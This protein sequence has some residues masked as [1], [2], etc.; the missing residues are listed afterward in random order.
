M[1]DVLKNCGGENIL[2]S[3]LNTRD[4]LEITKVLNAFFREI[5]E[6]W[7]EINFENQ[8]MSKEHFLDQ[9]LW[10]NSLIR[11]GNKPVFFKDWLGK[12]VT[13]VR[14]LLGNDNNTF[15]S[16]NNFCLKYNLNAHPLS[17]YGIVAAVKSLRNS[18][19]QISK[20]IIQEHGSF[21]ARM[22]NTQRASSLIYQKTS[23]Y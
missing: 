23:K 11:I 13:K 8:I 12:G 20:D 19:W 21:L 14:H 4:T 10:Y 1:D 5:L 6:I 22:V 7:G 18:T 9:P 16:L 2:T 15:L 3:N 17:F